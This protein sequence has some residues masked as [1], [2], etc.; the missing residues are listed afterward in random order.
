MNYIS[1]MQKVDRAQKIVQDNLCMLIIEGDLLIFVENLREVL[2]YVVH[3]E[4]NAQ[5]VFIDSFLG[6]NDIN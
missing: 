2:I 3:N 5:W 4:E 1:R 6:Y